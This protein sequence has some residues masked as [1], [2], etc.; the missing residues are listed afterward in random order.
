[1]SRGV[2]AGRKQSQTD[3]PSRPMEIFHTIDIMLSLWMRV[4]R[5]GRNLYFLISVSLNPL[6]SRSLVFFRSFKIHSFPGSTIT[7]WGLAVNQ[8]SGGDKN[9]VLHSLF[10]IFIIIIII[11]SSG[12]SINISFVALLNCLYLNPWVLPFVHFSSSSHWGGKPGV[13]EWWSGA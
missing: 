8:S 2:G 5:G 7:A 13:S 12:I 10:C 1:M 3:N 9:C 4:E 11:S 6:L